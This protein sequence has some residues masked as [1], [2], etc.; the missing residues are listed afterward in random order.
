MPKRVKQK[1]SLSRKD[2]EQIAQFIQ[3]QKVTE[4]INDR[5]KYFK[6]FKQTEKM[7]HDCMA[8]LREITSQHKNFINELTTLKVFIEK[9]FGHDILEFKEETVGRNDPK[10]MTLRMDK[11]QKEVR[12]NTVL[13]T[14]D[15]LK[16]YKGL[17]Q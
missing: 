3:S 2:R 16:K 1:S 4:L 14:I 7:L 6:M 15:L 5:D 10:V 8:K 9:N 11:G 12:F 13:L 17:T